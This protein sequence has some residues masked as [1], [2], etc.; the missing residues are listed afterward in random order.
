MNAEESISVWT[1]GEGLAWVVLIGMELGPV[2]GGMGCAEA[3]C[4]LFV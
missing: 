2:A 1:C 3:K 4:L